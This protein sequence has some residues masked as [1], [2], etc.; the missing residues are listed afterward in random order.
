[1]ISIKSISWQPT[2]LD[3]GPDACLEFIN[4]YFPAKYDWLRL[5]E[6]AATKAAAHIK[7]G[8]KPFE[9]GLCW[10]RVAVEL[11][12]RMADQLNLV[13]KDACLRLRL[14]ALALRVQAIATWGPRDD[15]SLLNPEEVITRFHYLIE[16]SPEELE[17]DSS[18]PRLP[19]IRNALDITKQVEPLLNVEPLRLKFPELSEYCRAAN[20][21][22]ENSRTR[23]V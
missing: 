14:P 23:I 15:D 8:E 2:L 1:M 11:Y 13:K 16:V 20:I 21:A 17:D 7:L 5:A 22:R 3:N 18:F 9:K 10:I 6:A 12:E 19:N 4:E